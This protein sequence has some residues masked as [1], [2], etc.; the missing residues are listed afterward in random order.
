MT[1][2]PFPDAQRVIYEQNPLFEVIC[3]LRFPPILKVQASTPADYQDRIRYLFPEIQEQRSAFD[4]DI[5]EE[6]LR[7]LHASSPDPVQYHRFLSE[8]RAS[9]SVTLAR[10]FIAIA[11]VSYTRW[12]Q[13]RD[14]VTVPILALESVYEPSFYRRIGL[15]YRDRIKRSSLGL[16]NC[17]WGELIKPAA[18]GG[19][20]GKELNRHS[21]MEFTHRIRLRW[22]EED[23]VLMQC[24]LEQSDDEE[25]F[26]IDFDFYS[27]SRTPIGSAMDTLNRFNRLAGRA[28]RWCITD[29]LHNKL[30]PKPVETT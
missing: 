6:L 23:A 27:D 10:D 15:R 14:K 2:A 19:L 7:L 3:Q 5:P 4:S 13:F 22:S 9:W 12:E 25:C 11:T 28:F 8:D 16:S 24:A 18:L 26:L 1:E 20:A 29:K 21:I 30:N 17:D